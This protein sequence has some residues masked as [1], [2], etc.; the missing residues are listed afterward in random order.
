[1]TDHN[2]VQ[3]ALVVQDA[4]GQV[5]FKWEGTLPTP[6]EGHPFVRPDPASV[7]LQA[8]AGT[9]SAETLRVCKVSEFQE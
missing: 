4:T 6:V 9:F 2:L 7:L 3:P 5:V 8:K 1:M